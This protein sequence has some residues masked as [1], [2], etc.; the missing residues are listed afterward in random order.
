VVC[1]RQIVR[2]KGVVCVE[3]WSGLDDAMNLDWTTASH[4]LIKIFARTT[5][6]LP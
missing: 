3:F 1:H 5:L 2:R 4:T 6:N